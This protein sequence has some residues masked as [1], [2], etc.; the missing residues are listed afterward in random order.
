MT[1]DTVNDAS[2][3]MSD[4]FINASFDLYGR[5]MSGKE[6][7]EPRWKRAM[8]IPNS[9]LGEAVGKLYVEK[10]FRRRTRNI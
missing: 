7:L 10:Y 8:A 4:Y 2:N 9:M 3:L 5:V 6:E 1:F